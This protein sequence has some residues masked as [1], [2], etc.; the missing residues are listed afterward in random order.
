[1]GKL[2]TTEQVKCYRDNGFLY[3]IKIF[4]KKETLFY[5]TNLEKYEKKMKSIISGVMRHK[6]HLYFRWIDE[7]VRN[8]KLLNAVEDI[9]GKNI[10]CWS[11]DFFIK[12]AKDE[13]YVSWHQDAKYWGLYP[14]EIITAWL[15]LSEA[16]VNKGPMEVIPKSHKWKV[17]NQIAD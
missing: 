4:S 15:A 14:Y 5:K 1:M 16:S 13:S 7:I 6:A 10:L 8:E 2:L 11:S 3:P 9:L 17:L 12:E